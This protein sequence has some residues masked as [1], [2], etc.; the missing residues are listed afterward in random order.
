[1]GDQQQ[2]PDLSKSTPLKCISKMPGTSIVCGGEIFLPAMKFRRISKFVVGQ[3][4]DQ[5]VPIQVFICS[6]CGAVPPEFEA[7]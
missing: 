4:N 3:P 6:N 7:M 1:M 5:I 2:M